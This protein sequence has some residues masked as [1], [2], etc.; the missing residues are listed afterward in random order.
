M[1]VEEIKFNAMKDL[2]IYHTD[3]E[4]PLSSVDPQQYCSVKDYNIMGK[5]TPSFYAI[6]DENGVI[7][8]ALSGHR[9]TDQ[10]YR[11]RGLYLD[12][13]FLRPE[14]HPF[15]AKT[16]VS[17]LREVARAEGCKIMWDLVNNDHIL[18]TLGFKPTEL[19]R[20]GQ[21]YCFREI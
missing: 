11:I 8:S 19:S 20:E 12:T 13:F 2:W 3:E 18:L 10:M 6:K 4:I 9:T 1:K 7:V 5:Y 14:D 16:L 15:H 21:V 17:K